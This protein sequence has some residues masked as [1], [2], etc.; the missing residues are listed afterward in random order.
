MDRIIEA[1]SPTLI[2]A[3]KKK[4]RK[5]EQEKIRLDKNIAKCG[6]PLQS[7]D[8]TFQTAISFLS[9]PQILWDSGSLEHKRTLLKLGFASNLT[10]CKKQGF[11]TPEKS[12]PL[13]LTGQLNEGKYEMVGDERFELPTSTV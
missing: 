8:E 10:Y 3:Y 2:T 12:Y 11:R 4:I 13:L 7:F 1:D 9:N 5:F 6:R